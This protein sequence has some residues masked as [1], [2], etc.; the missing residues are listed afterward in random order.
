[1]EKIIGEHTPYEYICRYDPPRD[2]IYCHEYC[3]T[4]LDDELYDSECPEKAIHDTERDLSRLK[5][6]HFLTPAFSDPKIAKANSLLPGDLLM[7]H[8]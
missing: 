8:L 7:S 1:M 3:P 6:C 2:V 4:R 5:M